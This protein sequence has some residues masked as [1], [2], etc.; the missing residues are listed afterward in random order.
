MLFSSLEFLYLFLPLTVAL[1]FAV[2]KRLR[3]LA[4]LVMSLVF[5]GVG[6]PSYLVLMIVTIIADYG[7]G[8]AIA[9]HPRRAKLLLWSAVA[10]NLALLVFFKYY[11][12]LASLLPV[13]PTLSVTLPIGIS[14][15]TFQALSYVIDV[16]R[17][18]GAAQR[19]LVSFGTYVTLFPQ[20]IAGPIVRYA[21]IAEGLSNRQST[22]SGAAAGVRRFCVGLAKKVLLANAAGALFASLCSNAASSVLGA[23]G[24]LLAY[25][26]QI[27]FDFSGYSDMAI[28][29]GLLFGFSFPENFNYPYVAK[30]IT[31]FWRRWHI[32]LS[33]WFREY[34]YIPLGGNRRGRARMYRNLLVTWAL[35]G[36]WHGASWNF[37][38]WGLYFF[39]ILSLEKLFLGR[40]LE[41]L[42]RPVRHAYALVLILGG[43]LI[44]ICD[45]S[46][47]GLSAA[48]GLAIARAMFGFFSLPLSDGYVR[49]ELLRHLPLILIMAVGATPLSARIFGRL[50]SARPRAT[51][52]LALALSVTGLLLSTAYLVSS[53]YNPFLYFRF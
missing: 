36:L 2:P 3:N 12:L 39:V 7:F 9:R 23:W 28:G 6:E 31:E 14:F 1:Y 29:L 50:S 44:F 22:M 49:Y 45:G 13:L 11:N 25:T 47:G 43:W 33:S 16:W 8:L 35:T 53:G 37:L 32:T 21:D 4:L 30:S 26:F 10:F 46:A 27:Y 42:P 40:L 18:S 48:D 19:N 24:T 20:L 41:R 51:A 15:Y 5:Y 38:L 17:G 34:V 52:L